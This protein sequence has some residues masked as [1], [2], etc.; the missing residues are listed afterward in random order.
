MD[1]VVEG[2]IVVEIKSVDAILP[3]HQAQLLTYLKASHRQVGLLIN[4]NVAVLKAGIRRVVNRYT[5]PALAPTLTAIS[6][7]PR[8]TPP[9]RDSAVN[10]QV[11]R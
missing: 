8:V 9:L 2:A 10:G 5:G 11:N 1:L 7:S 6:S 4:F 3:I